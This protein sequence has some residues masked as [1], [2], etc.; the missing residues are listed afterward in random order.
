MR[1]SRLAKI[2]DFVT[3]VWSIAGVSAL[4]PKIRFIF[5]CFIRIRIRIDRPHSYRWKFKKLAHNLIEGIMHRCTTSFIITL[6]IVLPYWQRL[7]VKRYKIFNAQCLASTSNKSFGLLACLDFFQYRFSCFANC[8][9]GCEEPSPNGRAGNA[10]NLCDIFGGWLLDT[11]TS[12]DK[13]CWIWLE[14]SL[15]HVYY[16][17]LFWLHCRMFN[18]LLTVICYAEGWNCFCKVVG[19]SSSFVFTCLDCFVQG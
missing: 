3:Q 4:S 1:K 18:G 12:R 10:P 11:S 9:A 6:L 5:I 7:S 2:I 14:V 8:L 15:C 17:K 13:F 16:R 19:P